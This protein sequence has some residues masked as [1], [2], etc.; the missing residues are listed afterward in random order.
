MVRWVGIGTGNP[1]VFQGYPYP[2]PRKPVPVPRGTG[3]NGYRFRKN[4]GVCNLC[5]GMPPKSRLRNLATAV[6]V[7]IDTAVHI[8]RLTIRWGVGISSLLSTMSLIRGSLVDGMLE[9]G[10]HVSDSCFCSCLRSCR[11]SA[12]TRDA[13]GS[14]L[15]W[16]NPPGLAQRAFAR[17]SVG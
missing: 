16:S 1:G 10:V 13:D 12:P 15:R 9:G 3:F 5:A 6:Q 8:A 2:Y 7:S 17:G 4:P 11:T 14:W